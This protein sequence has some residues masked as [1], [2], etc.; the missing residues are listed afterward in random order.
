MKGPLIQFEGY[1]GTPG[2]GMILDV[3][4]LEID[5]I[6]HMRETF[7]FNDRVVS[8]YVLVGKNIVNG[9]GWREGGYR[10]R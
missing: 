10:R 3:L 2:G 1:F 5:I 9:R 8:V 6:S 7:N 4:R